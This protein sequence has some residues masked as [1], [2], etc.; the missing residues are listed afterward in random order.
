[1]KRRGPNL[2]SCG[3]GLWLASLCISALWILPAGA[4]SAAPWQ[5]QNLAGSGLNTRVLGI[6]CPSST[7]CLAVGE[8][9]GVASSTNPTG[10]GAAWRTVR[11]GRG[12]TDHEYP[13]PPPGAPPNA[14][15]S[16]YRDIWAVS[17][18]SVRLCV[19]VTFDGYVFSSTNPTGVEDDWKLTDVDGDGRD[20]HL[21]SVSCPT[22]SL[23]V[24]VSGER[25]TPGKVLSS[26]NPTGGPEA[27]SVV[28]L[29]ES[30]DLR[31]VSCGTPT[32]CVAVA[33]NGRMLVS[34][35]P[36]GDASAWREL[37]T[38]GGP[39]DLKGISCAGTVL[40]LAGNFGGNLLAS[41]NPAGGASSWT[42]RN[43]G[44]SVLITGVSCLRS[45][46]CIAVDNNGDVLTS[47]N[48][49]GSR[50]D[51]SFQNVI[52]YRDP[53]NPFHGPDNAM[54]DVSCPS[55]SFCAIA[56]SGSRI[57]TNPDP[58]ANPSPAPGGRRVRQPRRP[59]VRLAHVDR[60]HTLTATG[61]ARMRFRFYANGK[62]S[63]FLCRLDK[64][65]VRRCRSP[66]QYRR[67]PVGK[68]VFRVWAV[69]LTGLKGPVALDRFR[70]VRNP[71]SR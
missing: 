33:E 15:P 64:R 70:I 30:L 16:T 34:T 40:C 46:Q 18:P 65:P 58:F 49:T 8:G 42:E 53:T 51:W 7:L 36:T 43:G 26:T 54:F 68:H 52:P 41:M 39:G 45:M 25:H 38:P 67:V 44:G 27:W 1:M 29:D 66:K 62:V 21:T 71:N 4:A 12:V 10:G 47:N 48:P 32:L 3:S 56:A 60:V 31:G 6:S 23:C 20:T 57:Y 2:R 59:N 35:N 11:P 28:Q 24:T 37:G 17:C 55:S 13:P 19:A 61:W 5:L 63:G 14:D 69:G 22:V 50:A 9:S